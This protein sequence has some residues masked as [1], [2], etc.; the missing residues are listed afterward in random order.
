MKKTF[1][2]CERGTAVLRVCRI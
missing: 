1:V 2:Y